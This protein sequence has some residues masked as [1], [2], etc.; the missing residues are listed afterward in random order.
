MITCISLL[1]IIIDG[2]KDFCRF[3]CN[4]ILIVETFSIVYPKESSHD[5]VATREITCK[6]PT[7]VCNNYLLH[8]FLIVLFGVYKTQFVLIVDLFAQYYR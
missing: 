8:N 5:I 3:N 7:K 4:F 1:K 2:T 6:Y